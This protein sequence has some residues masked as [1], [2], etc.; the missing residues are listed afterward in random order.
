MN[1]YLYI[2]KILI[3]SFVVG[4]LWTS[5]ETQN[6]EPVFDLVPKIELLSL[7]STE[8]VEFKDTLTL[9]LRYEDGDGDLGNSNPD[10]NS[11]FVQD[12]R[13]DEADEYFLGPLAPEDAGVSI[14]GN[15]NISLAPTFILG[16]GNIEETTYT[17]YM[18][19]RA[20]NQSN[21][22]ETEPITITRE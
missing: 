17:I 22:L 19:D 10:I 1:N 9:L 20:G 11:V 13:L 4:C 21:I 3:L 12:S 18:N 5:C 6:T 14:T 8:L 15:L 2:I 16:N 7:S